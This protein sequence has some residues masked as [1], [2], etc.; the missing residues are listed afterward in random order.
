[1]RAGPGSFYEV[2]KILPLLT[3]PEDPEAPAFDVVAPSLPNFGFSD[4]VS[5]KGFSISQYAETLHK[6][7]LNLEYDKYGMLA[8]PIPT[9]ILA[10]EC[11]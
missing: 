8:E 10:C 6:V 2:L 3:E 11:D 1:M 5:K 7:M 4:G 9:H